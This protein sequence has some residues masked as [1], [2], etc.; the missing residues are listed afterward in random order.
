VGGIDCSESAAPEAIV[1]TRP[2]RD[3]DFGISPKRG[4][5]PRPRRV[6]DGRSRWRSI[7]QG[8][9]EGTAIAGIDLDASH[10]ASAA[11]RAYGDWALPVP[12]F[13]FFFPLAAFFGAR[14]YAKNQTRA[15]R[16]VAASQSIG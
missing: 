11:P 10:K 1:A 15:E 2:C 4:F 6:F 13:S 3:G 5:A 8:S 9:V 16:A 12:W 7:G 14:D